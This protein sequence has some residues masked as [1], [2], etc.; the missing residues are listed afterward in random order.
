MK[1]ILYSIMAATLMLTGCISFDDPTVENYGNG[2]AVQITT[3]AVEDNAFTFTIT[4]ESGTQ[5]YSF[6]VAKETEPQGLDAA[7]LLSGKY[8]GVAGSV[9]EAA[10]STTYTFDMKQDGIGICSP[11]TSYV[12]YAV[13]ANDKGITGEVASAVVLTTDGGAPAPKTFKRDA[14]NKAVVL[15]MSEAVTR[16]EGAVTAKYYKEWDI[17]NP[18]VLTDE[19]ITVAVNGTEVTFA[20]PTA[21]AGAYVAFSYA[22]G[23]FKDSFGNKCNALNSGLDMTTGQFR[24]LVVQ[25]TPVP[26]DITDDNVKS[27]EDGAVFPE[28]NKFT[29]VVEFDFD[30][31][32]NDDTVENGDLSVV[33]TTEKKTSTLKLSAD[34]WSVEGNKLMFHLPEAPEAGAIVT[35]RVAEGAFTDV[36]GNPNKA[37]ASKTSWKYF[38]MTKEMVLGDFKF[39]YTSAYDETPKV[40]D[41]GAITISEDPEA[42]NG[43][44]IKNL[45]LSGSEIPARYDIKKGKLYIGARY[46]LGLVPNKDGGNY[47]LITYSMTNKDEI[48]FTV[49]VD[50]TITSDDLA[51]VACDEAYESALGYWEKCASATFTPSA[52]SSKAKAKA[53][54]ASSKSSLRHKLTVKRNITVKH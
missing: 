14:E 21:P 54:S 26:F 22:E 7:N 9:I 4:P 33:Y 3:G 45:Y 34:E 31:F 42:E 6:V 24:N 13:A 43:L 17:L 2:P 37:F 48:E 25:V 44:V 53:H 40:Y 11:N 49:N 19:D 35:L 32:R 39:T 10:K 15:T 29:G 18:V 46:E 23:A 36:Y 28:W 12:V 1:K 41:G 38:A 51:I 27:P 5:F 47:G 52:S 8:K 50:G 30:I 20:A 16:A